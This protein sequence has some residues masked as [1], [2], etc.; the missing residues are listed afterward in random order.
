ML[1]YT[2][3]YASFAM[4]AALAPDVPH[5]EGSFRPV[6]V[7]APPG[8]ILNATPPAAVGSRHTIGHFLPGVIFLALADAQPGQL[9]AGGAD[10]VWL[11]M[12]RGRRGNG[13][14]FMLGRQPRAVRRQPLL[15]TPA[16]R[17]TGDDLAALR[18]PDYSVSWTCP[19]S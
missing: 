14:W 16:R 15:G 1:N 11:T 12:M 3:A 10:S 6:H 9:L 4:K 17:R 8:S 5:N 2:H 18:E 19:Q 13:E 7:T